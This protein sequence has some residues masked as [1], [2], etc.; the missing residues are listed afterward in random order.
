[1]VSR[2]CVMTARRSPRLCIT[3]VR[4]GGVSIRRPLRLAEW[5]SPLNVPTGTPRDLSRAYFSPEF[6]ISLERLL[7]QRSP[8]IHASERTRSRW[9]NFESTR[10][11]ES[12]N[13]SN[14]RSA[15]VSLST[16]STPLCSWIEH[17]GA[18][19]ATPPS[20]HADASAHD[21][22]RA[23]VPADDRRMDR[24]DNQ[25]TGLCPRPANR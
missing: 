24:A 9:P 7:A 23:V 25:T 19:G 16:T 12:R 17:R 11:A 14:H 20:P 8:A 6:E 13:G 22:V 10:C 18:T 3:I 4:R 5:R 1:M 15:R 21:P 2:T